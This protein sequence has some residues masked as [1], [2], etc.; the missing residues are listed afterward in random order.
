MLC[1]LNKKACRRHIW[2]SVFWDSQP[3]DAMI[4]HWGIVTTVQVVQQQYF[5]T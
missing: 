1:L 5:Q 3:Y 2:S 4:R